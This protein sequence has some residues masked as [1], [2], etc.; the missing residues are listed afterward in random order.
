LIGWLIGFIR[1]VAVLAAVE[2]TAAM[3][4]TYVAGVG[5]RS[6][7][8]LIHCATSAAGRSWTP[9]EMTTVALLV[10]PASPISSAPELGA[11]IPETRVSS[12]HCGRLC[13]NSNMD[14]KSLSA[15]R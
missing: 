9:A 5:L 4:S 12:I 10:W 15:N 11:A 13:K 7:S 6:G 8:F 14:E 3:P 2:S 1:P